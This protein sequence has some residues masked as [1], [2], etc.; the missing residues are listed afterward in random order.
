MP[1][2]Y[3]A[4]TYL[5]QVTG[6]SC[7]R[8]FCECSYKNYKN[9]TKC[10]IF[11]QFRNWKHV[12]E[13]IHTTISENLEALGVVA[14][15]H[16]LALSLGTFDFNTS[17]WPVMLRPHEI[18][19]ER[20]RKVDGDGCGIEETIGCHI[21]DADDTTITFRVRKLGAVSLQLQTAHALARQL[22]I[23]QPPPAKHCPNLNLVPVPKLLQQMLTEAWDLESGQR[24]ELWGETAGWIKY[25]ATAHPSD[26]D[27]LAWIDDCCRGGYVAILT[28]TAR[29]NH[30]RLRRHGG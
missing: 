6:V 9:W 17:S 8:L 16:K 15:L 18:S 24:R 4:D 2:T 20:E 27:I 14:T 11:S 21:Y 19:W 30:N 29:Y 23:S 28:P 25:F 5:V 7:Y 1:Y 3:M 12:V 13:L 26:E 10:R 22:Y